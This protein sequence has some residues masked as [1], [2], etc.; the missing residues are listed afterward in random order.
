MAAVYTWDWCQEPEQMGYLEKTTSVNVENGYCEC[1]N[2][3]AH[4]S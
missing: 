1:F 4:F 2:D 3:K